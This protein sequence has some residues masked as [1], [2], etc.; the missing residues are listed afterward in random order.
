MNMPRVTQHGI[1]FD[2]E[3]GFLSPSGSEN[4]RDSRSAERSEDVA[5]CHSFS[6][7]AVSEFSNL[8]IMLNSETLDEIPKEFLVSQ[9]NF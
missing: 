8:L 7:N 5:L 2:S 9:K 1:R 4:P 3:G 6:V